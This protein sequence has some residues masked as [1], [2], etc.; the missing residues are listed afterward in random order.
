MYLTW[1]PMEPLLWI[2]DLK[3]SSYSNISEVEL[4][5]YND[6]NFSINCGCLNIQK[7]KMIN[8]VN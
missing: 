4:L 2:N 6:W 8:S 3:L 5:F 1:L 7:N